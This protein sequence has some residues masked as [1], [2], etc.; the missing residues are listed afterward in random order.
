M[1]PVSAPHY[2]ASRYSVPPPFTH[3]LAV[4]DIFPNVQLLVTR[5]TPPPLFQHP[6]SLFFNNAARFPS[7]DVSNPVL[8]FNLRTGHFTGSFLQGGARRIFN[9]AV[10]QKTISGVGVYSNGQQTLPVQLTPYP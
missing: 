6:F 7:S 9:G 4:S 2:S 5:S 3:I 10:L 1:S 8:K